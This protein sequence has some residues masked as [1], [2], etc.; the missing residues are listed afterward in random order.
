LTGP[1]IASSL[2]ASHLS[3]KVSYMILAGVAALN[4]LFIWLSFR[5]VEMHEEEDPN[6]QMAGD[7][8]S[9]NDEPVVRRGR[10]SQSV[11]LKFTWIAAIFLLFYV[12]IETTIGGWGYTF[13]TTAR[14]GDTVQMGR[15]SS[16]FQAMFRNQ[17]CSTQLFT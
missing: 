11:R 4:C 9:I 3:W 8:T 6:Y 15:V 1:L 16:I 10:F 14:G 2:F 5:K 12:G 17:S 7:E 13:L